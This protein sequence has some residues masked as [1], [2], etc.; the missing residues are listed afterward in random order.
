MERLQSG[1]LREC[2]HFVWMK[3][4]SIG[5]RLLTLFCSWICCI[6]GARMRGQQLTFI[7]LCES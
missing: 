3:I 4:A 6:S 5:C 1:I 2:V 7:S